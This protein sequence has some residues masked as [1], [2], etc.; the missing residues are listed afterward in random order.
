MQTNVNMNLRAAGALTAHSSG[1][2]T[3]S[4]FPMR[5][6]Y[7]ARSTGR[8]KG[9]SLV[10]L[11]V[12]VAIV[13]ILAS[14]AAPS[15]MSMLALNRLSSQ[16]ND[17]IGAIQY[18]RSEAIKLNRSVSLC[19]VAS[20]VAT[21]CAGGGEWSHWVVRSDAGMVLR[22]GSVSGAGTT[23]RVS[24]TL[25][26]DSLTFLGSGLSNASDGAN[27]LRV[28]TSSS[29]SDNISTLV[30]GVTGRTI[31]EKTSGVC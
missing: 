17:F 6:A 12:T 24:S 25:D 5:F 4:T 15:F 30:I 18:A 19:R 13:A 26:D 10:E 27:A 16:T 1:G 31:L 8:C 9:F 3:S 2:D 29:S 11:M 14:V 21:A 22:R 7:G 23:L 20:A 28:C